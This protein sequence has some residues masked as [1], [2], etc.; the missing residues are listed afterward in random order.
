M[1]TQ[2]LLDFI[3]QSPAAFNAIETI[4]KYLKKENFIEIF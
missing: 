1:Y 4:K 2:E 3:Y